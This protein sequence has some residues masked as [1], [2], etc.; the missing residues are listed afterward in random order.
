MK[1]T[2]TITIDSHDTSYKPNEWGVTDWIR[3]GLDH[4]SAPNGVTYG[5]F[6]Q[7][8][9]PEHPITRPMSHADMDLSHRVGDFEKR[10]DRHN[11]RIADLGV[12]LG[13]RISDLESRTEANPDDMEMVKRHDKGLTSL[14]YRV[15]SVENRL[16]THNERISDCSMSLGS[17]INDLESRT[18]AN[19]E[20]LAE[21]VSKLAARLDA[22]RLVMGGES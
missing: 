14:S 15:D 19:H 10:L 11:D 13:S 6:A 18:E 4:H 9:E 1:H 7:A 2:F 12:S 16:D 5:V 8:P 20:D 22:I 3:R 17:R 21:S